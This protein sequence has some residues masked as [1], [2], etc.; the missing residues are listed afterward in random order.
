MSRLCARAGIMLVALTLTAL[1]APAAATPGQWP[2]ATPRVVDPAI[3]VEPALSP[4]TPIAARAGCDSPSCDRDDDGVPDARDVCPDVPDP[5][6]ADLDADGVGDACDD[7]YTGDDAG[8]WPDEATDGGVGEAWAGDGGLAFDG[9][10]GGC[11]MTPG[12]DAPAT[13]LLIVAFLALLALRVRR[14]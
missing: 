10:S 6:Q 2:T 9:Y 5:E 14:R 7:D 3:P 1:I 8:A 4:F 12:T 13:G 11:A